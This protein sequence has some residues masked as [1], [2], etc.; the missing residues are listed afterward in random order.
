[1]KKVDKSD[2]EWREQLTEEQ[3]R[4]ARQKGTERAFTGIYWDHKDEGVYRCVCCEAPLFSSATKYD[5]G[6]G[7]PSYYEPVSKEAIALEEDATLGMRRTE[8]MCAACGAHLGHV[9]PDGPA[10]TGERYCINSASL[11]F[12]PKS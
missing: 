1:M 7:W 5:S 11:A 4:I 6:S 3:Y 12:V 10:P 9:F 2:A 8:V